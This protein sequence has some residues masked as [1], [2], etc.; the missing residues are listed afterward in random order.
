MNCESRLFSFISGSLLL[1]L[2]PSPNL[3][4]HRYRHQDDDLLPNA[5]TFTLSPHRIKC[6]HPNCPKVN[7]NTPTMDGAKRLKSQMAD[8]NSI[9][10]TIVIPNNCNNSQL[11]SPDMSEANELH[12]YSSSSA[13]L[14]TAMNGNDDKDDKQ[15]TSMLKI[16]G[17]IKTEQQSVGLFFDFEFF[18]T[19]ITMHTTYTF[20]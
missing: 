19:K 9:S 11:S 5:D 1:F 12:R 4:F 6:H 18:N 13:N 17:V 10:G 2:F 20:E 16:P 14:A 8:A 7:Q 3:P 15:K